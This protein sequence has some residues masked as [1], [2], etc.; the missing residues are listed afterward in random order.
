MFIRQSII[1]L[2]SCKGENYLWRQQ[3]DDN[4]DPYYY[5]HTKVAPHF[6]CFS[7]LKVSEKE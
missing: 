5:M 4:D 3:K 2:S 7:T 6:F 1:K